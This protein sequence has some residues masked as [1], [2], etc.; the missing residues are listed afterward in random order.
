[1]KSP[2]LALHDAQIE[3]IESDINISEYA[4]GTMNFDAG[5]VEPK[6]GEWLTDSI[7]GAKGKVKSV[8]K[9]SGDWA[10]E[11]AAGS[12]ELE[13]C[14]G[15]FNDDSPI[16][17]SKG[18]EGMLT[19]N[20][21]DGSVGADKHVK[22]GAFATDNDPPNDWTPSANVTLTTEAGGQVGNCM[23]VL[24]SGQ[25]GQLAYQAIT[26]VIGRIYK[27]TAYAKKGTA[28]ARVYVGLTVTGGE[29]LNETETLGVWTRY[30]FVFEATSTTIYI[31][32]RAYDADGEYAYLDEVTLYEINP[33]IYKVFDDMPE[34]EV[35]PYIVMGEITARDWS[36]KFEPG[37]EVYSTIHIWSRYKGRKEADDM[38]DG[39]LQ[40]LTESPL[41]LSPNFRAVLDE[42]ESYDLIIDIDGITRHGILRLR[43]LIEEV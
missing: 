10:T 41:D 6:L 36:D 16:N 32:C 25:D 4:V 1:M 24:N 17:G 42:F 19:V 9:I 5:K 2:T 13:K 43:Y 22:N 33:P 15:C 3:R 39:V 27:V 12:I 35:F 30:T 38:A 37:Q 11:D 7:S 8:S 14:K 21:P 28:R 23:K 18:G 26:T 34:Q 20:H 29:Y 31:T 40:A